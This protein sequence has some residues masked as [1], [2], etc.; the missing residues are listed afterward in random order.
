MKAQ[1]EESEAFTDEFV[2]EIVGKASVSIMAGVVAY[3]FRGGALLASL[4]ST[5]PLWRA[6]DPLPILA[7]SHK[8][9]EEDPQVDPASIP[10][11]VNA[12]FE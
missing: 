4:L 11:D 6:Y 10:N 1:M 12:L 3:A 2:V 5:M 9:P 7:A 8:K